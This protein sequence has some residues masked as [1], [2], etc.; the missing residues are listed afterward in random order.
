MR[1]ANH[2]YIDC[3]FHHPKEYKQ[4]LIVMY[5]DI[6]TDLKI[7]GIYIL[8]NNKTQRM[9]SL[10]F[11]SLIHILTENKTYDLDIKSIITDSETAFL[12][13]LKNFSLIA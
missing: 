12:K 13:Q 7:P 3:T 6:I 2:Y 1:K 10:A 8:L 11:E 9:Y 5:K 4:L